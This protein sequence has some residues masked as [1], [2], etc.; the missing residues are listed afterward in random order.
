VYAGEDVY[1]ADVIYV[2]SGAD[3]E[4]LYPELF[5][6]QP[7][8][9]CKLQMMRL[10][11]QP[12]A[13]RIGPAMCGALSLAHYQ[14]FKAATSLDTLKKR[15][16]AEY[17]QH[18]QLGIHVMAAQH[19]GGEI[20]VGDS[21]EYGL[22]PEPFDKRHINELILSY[23]G[24]F[25]NLNTLPLAESWHGVY[26]K[27]TDGNTHLIIHPEQGVTII[28]GVGGAGMTFSFG[29]AATVITN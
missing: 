23:L 16:E 22:S 13:P 24:G 4:T 20:T 5:S 7:L 25:S 9:K 29:L 27:R 10:Q 1:E 17:P 12:G 18:L 2:C 6:A 3:F 28:N 15:F 21:H 8:T 14:S 19:E 11:M 26:A